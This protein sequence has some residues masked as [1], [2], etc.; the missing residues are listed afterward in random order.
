MSSCIDR[1]QLSYPQL[2]FVPNSLT[3]MRF[4]KTF[5]AALL[6]LFVFCLLFVLIISVVA[7]GGDESL[8][9]DDQSIL[10]LTLSNEIVDRHSDNPFLF[11]KQTL[12]PIKRDGLDNILKQ[13]QKAKVDDRIQGIFLDTPG[14]ATGIATLQEIREQLVDFKESGKWI[15]AYNDLFTQGGYYLASVADEVYLQPEGMFELK[16]LAANVTFMKEFLDKIGID[17]QVIRPKNN[18]FKSAVEPFLLDSMSAANEEQLSKILFSIWDFMKADIASSRGMSI[19]ALESATDQLDSRSAARAKAAGLI[20]D[21]LYRDQVETK[22]RERLGIDPDDELEFVSLSEYKRAS[23]SDFDHPSDNILADDKVAIIYAAGSID[24]G[25]HT[26]DGIGSDGIAGLIS[27]ARKDSAI[28]AIVL[29]VN[30]G[31]G[32]ALASD[33]IWREMSLAKES[34][35]VV[36]S[37]GDVAASGGYY[38][39]CNADR[40]YANESTITGSIG[41]FGMIP[42]V[43]ELQEEMLGLHTD[44]VKTNPYADMMSIDR[45]LRA[46]ERAMWQSAVDDIYSDFTGKVAQGR[47]LEQ[48]YVNSIGQGRVWSGVDAM[49]IDLIDMYGGLEEAVAGAAELAGLKDYRVKSYPEE[50]DPVQQIINELTGQKAATDPL[51]HLAQDDLQLYTMVKRYRELMKLRGVQM[52]MPMVLEIE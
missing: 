25:D 6:A 49:D 12:E 10:H 30:S 5:L 50:L 28:K 14:P 42:N 43:E 31:G 29:R 48:E 17:V 41:V 44:G 40:I 26:T 46:D 1:F 4:F 13:I 20:T 39:S 9:V 22:L 11:D 33:V 27:E 36:V 23:V 18:K 3:Y 15:I 35:K 37:F 2:T 52:R 51:A 19:E 8:T 45:P 32:S 16:G 21:A 34:K 47:G 38:I 24:M 7:S